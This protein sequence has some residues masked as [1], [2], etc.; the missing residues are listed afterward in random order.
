MDTKRGKKSYVKEK[1]EIKCTQIERK[2]IN[3]LKK[4]DRKWSEKKE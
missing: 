1:G 4:G 3:M 2:M